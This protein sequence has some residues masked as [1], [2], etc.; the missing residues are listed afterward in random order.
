MIGTLTRLVSAQQREGGHPVPEGR[1]FTVFFPF[2]PKVGHSF[3]FVIESA[4]GLQF[5]KPIT[6]NK[7]IA[8]DSE[9]FL[10]KSSAYKLIVIDPS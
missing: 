4:E 6:T 2:M 10:T 7:V 3:Y 8:V 5:N 9:G 1:E